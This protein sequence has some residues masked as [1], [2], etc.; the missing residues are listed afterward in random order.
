MKQCIYCGQDV[1]G[2]RKGEHV[3]PKALGTTVAIPRV[4]KKCNNNELSQ[5]DK[6]FV[7]VPPLHIASCE[8]LDIIGDNVWDYNAQLDLAIEGRLVKNL[9][10]VVQWPQVVLDEGQSIFCYDI[11]EVEKV[12][13]QVCYEAFHR[14]LLKAVETVRRNDRRPKFRWCSIPNPPRRGRFPPRV[15][16]RHKCDD[17]HGDI[18]F[19]CRYHGSI[20]QDGVLSRLE[21]WHIDIDNTKELSMLGVNDPETATSY[22]PRWILRALV[23]IGINLLAYVM[24]DDF[25]RDAF[26]DATQFV[27]RDIGSGPSIDECGFL[28][29]KITKLLGCPQNSH[30]FIL[31]H[32]RNWALDCSFFGGIVGATVS[33]PGQSWGNINRIEIVAP[34]G[35]SDWK[36]CKS[37]ILI[38]RRPLVTDQI[39]DILESS[40]MIM[41]AQSRMRVVKQ[42]SN[43]RKK[44]N[45][46]SKSN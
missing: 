30:K 9:S 4:C 7:S 34:L 26:F 21:V 46:D 8:E 22:R 25:R 40:T 2:V 17:L 44:S 23:K 36:V 38:P 6:E 24:K 31:Q 18:S 12:G 19:E 39:V 5:L 42:K 27:L 16:T 14:Q 29:K 43:H 10:V 15:F 20:D 35:S 37:Q 41:N 1:H 13:L 32:D 33:F 3:V 11:Q 28:H 45:Q